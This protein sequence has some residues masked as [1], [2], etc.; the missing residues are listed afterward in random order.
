MCTRVLIVGTGA[1]GALLGSRLALAPNTLV[2]A[3]CR[4]NYAAVAGNGLRITSPKFGAY[5]FNPTHTFPD[6]ATA[7]KITLD[8]KLKWDFLLVTTKALPELGDAS[9][10][11]EGLVGEGT[12]VVVLQNGLG[13]EEAFARR[14]PRAVVVSGVTVASAVQVRPGEVRHERWTRTSVGPYLRGGED[15]GRAE[16][17]TREFATLLKGG[18]VEDV[19]VYDYEGLQFVRWHKVAINAA[20]N[21]SAVLSGGCGNQAL[22]LDDE[23]REHI[24]GVMKEVLTAAEA[25]L[26]KKVPWEE[27]RMATPEQIIESVKRN[28]TGSRPSMW[29]DWVHGRRME[30]EVILGAP[31]RLARERGVEMPRVQSMYSLL[32]MAEKRREEEGRSKL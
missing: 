18:G 13:V 4:S 14:F 31:L 16:E 6:A 26:G 25:V 5:T 1:I 23:L 9:E 2:S 24:H 29:Y 10:V 17:K 15:K 20:M 32:R 30:L 27:L 22:A 8:E 21:P 11:L 19:E 12:A 3:L 7:R 28:S